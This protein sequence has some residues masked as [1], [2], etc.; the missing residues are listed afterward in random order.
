MQDHT[1]LSD[2]DTIY[3]SNSNKFVK[4]EP[5]HLLDI[6]SAKI[7]YLNLKNIVSDPKTK[8]KLLY[9]FHRQN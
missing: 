1:N 7:E 5:V 3:A 2:T 8:T 6:C 9:L 4:Q